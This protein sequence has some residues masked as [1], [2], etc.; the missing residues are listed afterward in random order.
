ML[1]LVVALAVDDGS[2]FPKG[3][4]DE[5]CVKRHD[6]CPK[7]T[8]HPSRIMRKVQN[9]TNALFTVRLHILIYSHFDKKMS[10][11]MIVN[12]P[13]HRHVECNLRTYGAMVRVTVSE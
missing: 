12:L 1:T 10:M 6:G 7:Q 9:V 8:P 3:S 4:V 13:L 11:Q 5:A 2:R